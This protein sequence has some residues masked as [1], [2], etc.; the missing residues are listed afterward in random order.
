MSARGGKGNQCI[1]DDGI[2]WW[3]QG[4]AP[5]KKQRHLFVAKANR[6]RDV[7]PIVGLKGFVVSIICLPS[8]MRTGRKYA[9][10]KFAS[11]VGKHLLE[12]AFTTCICA[13]LLKVC[14]HWHAF[15]WSLQIL[16][17]AFGDGLEMCLEMCLEFKKLK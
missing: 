15:L 11:F 16:S 8:W 1:H 7:P 3:L 9:C 5:C 2:D 17:I 13:S 6:L 12:H 10:L 4:I 14:L